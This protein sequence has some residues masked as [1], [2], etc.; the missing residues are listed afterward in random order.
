MSDILTDKLIARINDLEARLSKL[1]ANDRKLGDIQ[2]TLG[3]TAGSNKLT[4]RDSTPT[5]V[6]S[7]NSDGNIVTAGTLSVTG[8]I[9]S[10]GAI[11]SVGAVSGTLGTFT[12]GVA[13]PKSS[14][15]ALYAQD[16]SGTGSSITIGVGS[17]ATPLGAGVAL[18]G[19]LSVW[20]N[21]DGVGALY[22]ADSGGCSII[23]DRAGIFAA[24]DTASKIC[25]YVTGSA[26]TIKNNRA[27]SVTVSVVC[28][29]VA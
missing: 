2:L 6:F 27:G 7:V 9:A 8:T 23:S 1:E 10:T 21:G 22:F 20:S 29:R 5:E 17:T 11:S 4:L 28:W 14:G 15:T 24:A 3:D 25:A 26:L 18:R 13:L 12:S 19:I 16:V